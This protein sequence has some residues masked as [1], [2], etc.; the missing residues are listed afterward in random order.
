MSDSSGSL[1]PPEP[2]PEGA[3]SEALW[4][5]PVFWVVVAVVVGLAVTDSFDAVGGALLLFTAV[6]V[7]F[8]PA[9]I[10]RKKHNASSVFVVN[11]FFGWTLI[12]WV[13]ALAMAVNNPTPVAV[14]QPQTATSAAPLTEPSPERVCPFCAEDIRAAAIVC[15]HCGRDL[16]AEN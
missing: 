9:W 10:A 16:P 12:G 6:A 14:A 7:Y 13:I 1:L 15:K 8:L 3:P 4:K 2:S 5:R 11:L